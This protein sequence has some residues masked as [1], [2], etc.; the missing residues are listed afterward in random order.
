MKIINKK[1]S[2]DIFKKILI[3]KDKNKINDNNNI[4]YNKTK[5]KINEDNIKIVN[6]NPT[7][8]KEVKFRILEVLKNAPKNEEK[9]NDTI[10]EKRYDELRDILDIL[11]QNIY[12]FILVVNSFNFQRY[13]HLFTFFEQNFK[14]F[15]EYLIKIQENI[16]YNLK[17]FIEFQE[18]YGH[19]INEFIRSYHNSSN[20][21]FLFEINFMLSIKI[22]NKSCS[23]GIQENVEKFLKYSNDYLDNILKRIRNK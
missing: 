22:Q 3:D 23:E 20:T 11:L 7:E 2:F 16:K 14:Y 6:N 9:F 5:E 15:Y 13:L 1:N 4:D 8:K 10:S 19:Q 17:S 21:D 18:N 12:K